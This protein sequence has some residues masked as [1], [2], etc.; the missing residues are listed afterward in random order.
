MNYVQLGRTGVKIAPLTLGTMN[1]GYWQE[2]D[3]S[4]KIMDR[5]M[6]HGINFFDSCH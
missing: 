2:D 5:A 3:V 1:F 6:E 4:F